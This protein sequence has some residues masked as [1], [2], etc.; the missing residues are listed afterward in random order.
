V[1]K[2]LGAVKEM[3]SAAFFGVGNELDSFNAAFTL[4]SF[5]VSITA[6]ALQ[7]AQVPIY[8]ETKQQEGKEAAQQLISTIFSCFLFFLF[9]ISAILLFVF[10]YLLPHIYAG[11]SPAKI[12]VTTRLLYL[13][14]P[15]IILSGASLFVTSIL[16]AEEEFKFTALIPGWTALSSIVVLIVWG[17]SLGIYA[18]AIGVVVGALI[19]FAFLTYL[20][21]KFGILLRPRW[22]L[23]NEKVRQVF[24]STLPIIIAFVLSGAMP[25][26]DQH[27]AANL[28]EGDVA[29]LG[30]GYRIISLY[31]T[32]FAVAVG[33][34][35]LPHFSKLAAEKDW[36]GLRQAFYGSI[37]KFIW[38]ICVLSSVII[39]TFSEPIVRTL[40]QRGAFTP[41]ATKTVA[42]IQTMYALQLPFYVTV[43]ISFRLLS[44]MMINRYIVW[45]AVTSLV[46]CFIFDYTFS[47][48]WGVNGI[49]LSVSA[50][51]V[52]T[53]IV[54]LQIIRREICKRQIESAK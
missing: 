46:A 8:L 13:L 21:H 43:Y 22:Q 28:R 32:L 39:I 53:A 37:Y 33:T 24:S 12:A 25:L 31:L 40:F 5:V 2:L 41:E 47:H 10:P 51:Y 54:T 6:G 1:V 4:A 27:F 49:A 16:N 18:L 7:I 30:F 15:L 36:D 45:I 48:L 14:V 20:L 34:T 9:V 26:I 11:F 23:D 29:A 19:E 3:V 50:V 35:V 42:T 44:A 38:P 52:I 17:K